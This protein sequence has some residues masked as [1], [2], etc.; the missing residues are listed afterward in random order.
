MTASAL[1]LEETLLKY[2]VTKAKRTGTAYTFSLAEAQ[3]E[4]GLQQG[5]ILDLI[6]TLA[7]HGVLRT[8]DV[9]YTAEIQDR[10]VSTLE[11]SEIDYALGHLFKAE[12]TDRRNLVRDMLVSI[13]DAP[14][15]PVVFSP[16]GFASKM[17][18]IKR[19]VEQLH[20]LQVFQKETARSRARTTGKAADRVQRD[21]IDNL[22]S[23][24][25]TVKVMLDRFSRLVSKHAQELSELAE[26][27]V[28]LEIRHKI[29]EYSDQQLA[30][31]NADLD[32][33]RK[34]IAYDLDVLRGLAT[35]AVVVDVRDREDLEMAFDVLRARFTVSEME[36][37]AF[38]K[39]KEELTE[40]LAGVTTCRLDKERVE[41]AQKNARD[42][43]RLVGS[44]SE[45]RYIDDELAQDLKHVIEG[46]LSLTE[47]QQHGTE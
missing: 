36:L 47:S 40:Q 30:E 23:E 3:K 17:D 46:L 14:R 28:E 42:L 15:D 34:A 27:R 38:E 7:M 39:Q 6:C 1:L 5:Q 18:K 43:I 16:D 35:N 13:R 21:L 37:D 10:L 12:L 32:T 24:T 41:E 22:R 8:Q 9:P 44:I 45:K 2:I 4:L 11:D 25:H 19:L 31:M 29:G 26:K 20:R 33:R